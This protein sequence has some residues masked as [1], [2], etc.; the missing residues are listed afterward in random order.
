LISFKPRSRLNW[1]SPS[2]VAPG[3]RNTAR[4]SRPPAVNI[5]WKPCSSARM[6]DTIATVAPMPSTVRNVA[7]LRTNKLRRL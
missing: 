1:L 3:R 6:P 4:S 2:L 7:L 5:D